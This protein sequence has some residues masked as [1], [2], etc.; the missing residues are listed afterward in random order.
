MSHTTLP[1]EVWR[2]ILQ[3]ATLPPGGLITSWN[4]SPAERLFQGWEEI[5]HN[6]PTIETK[7]S[8]VLVCKGWFAIGI[9]F[10]YQW[11][12]IPEPERAMALLEVLQA[13]PGHSS[14]S[15]SARQPGLGWWVKR[16]DVAAWMVEDNKLEHLLVFLKQCF[17]VEMLCFIP[18][19]GPISGDHDLGLTYLLAARFHHSL[20]HIRMRTPK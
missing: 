19:F 14:T 7:L 20:R 6:D 2:R 17:H 5:D 1:P 16:I 10:L 15:E 13:S 12:R 4:H 8:I 18:P 11:I 9:E 3:E